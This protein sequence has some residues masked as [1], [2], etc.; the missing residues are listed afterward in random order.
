[1]TGSAAAS[2]IDL[3]ALRARFP[4]TL[5]TLAALP[6]G[7]ETV[8]HL[9]SLERAFSRKE[10]IEIAET[11][12]P[13]RDAHPDFDVVLAGGGLSLVY[14]AT[15]ARAG[16]KVAIFDRRAIGCGHREWNISRA[17]L[18]P[19][20]QAGLFTAEEVERLVALEYKSGIIR[21]HG[22][23]TYPVKGV[24]DCV[25][26]AERLLVE[27]TARAEAAGATLLPY[28]RLSGYQ[29]GRGGV[30][31]QL[32]QTNDAGASNPVTITGRLLIDGLGA[33]SPHAAF[34]LCCPT[35][36]GV[37]SGLDAGDGPLEVDPLLGEILVTTEDVEEDRQHIWE[38]F[39]GPGG[40]FTAYLFYY[41]EP[42]RLPEHPLLELYERF[43]I[44]RPRYKRG[45]ARLDK[46]TYGFIP[47]YSRLRPMPTAPRDRVI[48]VGDAAGRHSPLTFCGFGSMIRSFGPVAEAL[49]AR[50][51]DDRLDRRSLSSVWREP[52]GL[53]VMG[54][55]TLM[56]VPGRATGRDPKQVNRL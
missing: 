48:L 42:A 8:A 19:L 22:G 24:L 38:G 54:G 34:D 41:T 12:G 51:D 39:P 6:A 47:A 7:D 20:T 40:R 21:W 31:V 45:A 14:G 43:F 27:L 53:Q 30:R 18:A 35:V 2:E 29:V 25:V 4:R 5:E 50:L 11:G 10:P 1:M 36:G 32:H 33:S 46:A 26:D 56:M 9:L 44:A 28:H 15:L 49:R 23:G 52:A 17:E 3:A 13:D 55:L 16:L 37:L